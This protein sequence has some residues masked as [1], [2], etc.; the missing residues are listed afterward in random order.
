MKRSTG[1]GIIVLAGAAVAFWQYPEQVKAYIPGLKASSSE[2]PS[3][4]ST[5][6]RAGE[7]GSKAGAGAKGPGAPGGAGGAG[8]GGGKRGGFGGPVAVGIAT[9]DLVDIP[10]QLE[11]TGNVIAQQSVPIRAQVN[12]LIQRVAV[13]EGQTVRAG[14]VLF[15]LDDRSVQADLTKAEAQAQRSKA[16]LADLERQLA[17]AKDLFKK[18]FIASS[19]VDTAATQVDAQRGQVQ[20][21]EAAIKAQQIQRSLYVIR[22]PFSGRIGSIDVSN[23]TLVSSGTAG[24]PL[25]TLTQFDPIGVRF[26]LPESEVQRITAAGIGRGVVVTLGNNALTTDTKKHPGKLT[27]IDNTINPSTGMLTLKAS[28]PNKDNSLWPGQFVN[29]TV[30]VGTLKQA[31]VIP[32]AAVVIGERGT[33][34][35]TVGEEDK[36]KVKPIKVLHPMGDK[37]AVSGLVAGDR[38]VVEGRDNVKPGAALRLPGAGGKPGG[39]P[40]AGGDK[41]GAGNQAGGGGKPEGGESKGDGKKAWNGKPRDEKPA[42]KE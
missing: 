29:V 3:G 22:A 34:V 6:E 14:D 11:S 12:A 20:A 21:D 28:L 17:R 26:S 36:A 16:T 13:K 32:Q 7:T 25:T 18:N 31:A 40:Q 33:I 24:T 39:G 27:L 15:E 4:A 5:G 10:M 8:G 35:Y 38:I 23:G 37:V 42:G 30:D 1:F 19:A 41:L 2:T 9:I